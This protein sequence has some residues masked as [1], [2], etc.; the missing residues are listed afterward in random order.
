MH[1]ETCYSKDLPRTTFKAGLA[2]ADTKIHGNASEDKGWVTFA[3]TGG[4]EVLGRD[5]P[6][7]ADVGKTAV[8]VGGAN[9]DGSRVGGADI[10]SK[11]S[12]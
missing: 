9:C 1:K 2:N 3:S 10:G 11:E 5:K 12:G 8:R 7:A 4:P 6:V